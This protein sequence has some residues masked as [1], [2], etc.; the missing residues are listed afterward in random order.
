MDQ[1]PLQQ[2]QAAWHQPQALQTHPQQRQQLVPLSDPLKQATKAW[3]ANTGN[4]LCI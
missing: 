4:F 3:N 2:A 1:D